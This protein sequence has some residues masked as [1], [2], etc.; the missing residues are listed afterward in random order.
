MAMGLVTGCLALSGPEIAPAA[1]AQGPTLVLAV[2]N[3]SGASTLVEFEHEALGTGGAG[4]AEFPCG[5]TVTTFGTVTGSYR[6][7]V[8][9]EEVDAGPVPAPAPGTPFVVFHVEIAPDGTTRVARPELAQRAPEAPP[10]EP[11]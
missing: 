4:G 3:R 9:G 6:L 7:K 10:M 5:S 2:T 8:E 11:C 1:P